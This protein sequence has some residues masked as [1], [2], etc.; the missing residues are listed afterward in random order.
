MASESARV[1]A[2]DNLGER[3]T[4]RADHHLRGQRGDVHRDD[5]EVR[6]EVFPARQPGSRMVID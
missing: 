2:V 4:T 3:I 5:V 6:R 1:S